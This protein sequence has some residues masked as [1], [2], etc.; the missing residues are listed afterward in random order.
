MQESN[1][2]ACVCLSTG[3]RYRWFYVFSMLGTYPF[4][5]GPQQDEYGVY[6]M[7]LSEGAYPAP[8]GN[9]KQWDKFQQ[10]YGTDPTGML[11]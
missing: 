8:P 9:E 6:S 4:N 11:S 10:I 5:M 2:F 1:V 7:K 3:G